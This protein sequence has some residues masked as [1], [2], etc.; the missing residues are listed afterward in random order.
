MVNE[1]FILL[2]FVVWD[3]EEVLLDISM[4]GIDDGFIY[5]NL[6]EVGLF[7]RMTNVV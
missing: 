1:S 2:I 4:I 5:L 6:Y 3:G 7:V